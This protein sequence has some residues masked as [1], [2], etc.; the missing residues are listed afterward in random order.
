MEKKYRE[1]L[2]YVTKKSRSQDGQRLGQRIY[3]LIAEEDTKTGHM[4]KHYKDSF[5]YQEEFHQ[6]LFYIEDDELAGIIE[7]AHAKE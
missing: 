3:N 5:E 4:E 1:R 7:R 2:L 6:R